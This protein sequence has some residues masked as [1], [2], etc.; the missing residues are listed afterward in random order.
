MNP[1][2]NKDLLGVGRPAHWSRARGPIGVE[3]AGVRPAV[4]HTSP[5]PPKEKPSW[6]FEIVLLD[7]SAYVLSLIVIP[8]PIRPPFHAA[9]RLLSQYKQQPRAGRL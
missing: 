5:P 6:I 8:D 1:L 7:H 2:H 9:V 3:A 4:L